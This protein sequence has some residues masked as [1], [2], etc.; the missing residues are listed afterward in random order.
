MTLCDKKLAEISKKIFF[1][2]FFFLF[3]S[4][5][6]VTDNVLL[7]KCSHFVFLII[8]K[9]HCMSE[10]LKISDDGSRCVWLAWL[11]H[12]PEEAERGEYYTLSLHNGA[13]E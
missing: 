9:V 11:S 4:R 1:F 12:I 13:V 2:L 8:I 6:S 5:Q 3:L 7:L 10:E